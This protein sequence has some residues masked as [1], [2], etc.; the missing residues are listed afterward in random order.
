M[1]MNFEKYAFLV[2]D[3]IIT[4]EAEDKKN[5]I[6]IFETEFKMLFGMDWTIKRVYTEV[7]IKGEF[8]RY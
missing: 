1:E 2:N 4:I 6:D 5:A 8:N 7:T 3:T